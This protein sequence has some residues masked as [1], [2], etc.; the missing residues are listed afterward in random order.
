MGAGEFGT[1]MANLQR[2]FPLG[3]EGLLKTSFRRL[4]QL[5]DKGESCGE[6]AQEGI[7]KER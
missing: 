7:K 2:R 1:P 6:S 3:L 5:C 4:V